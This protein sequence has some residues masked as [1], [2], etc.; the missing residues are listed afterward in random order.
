MK[1]VA[2]YT[3]TTTANEKRS[4]KSRSHHR[5]HAA[6]AKHHHGG[7]QYLHNRRGG[8]EE[9]EE[10]HLSKRAVGDVVSATID[11]QL[12]SWIN[13]Y[14]GPGV[15]TDAPVPGGANDASASTSDMDTTEDT[16]MTSQG[17]TWSSSTTTSTSSSSS[18]SSTSTAPASNGGWARQAYFNA[19]SGTAEGLTFLNHFGGMDGIPG[20]SAGG[21][22]SGN[23]DH[24]ATK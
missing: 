21:P 17:S 16:E 13:V 10:T 12:V 3:P 4:T 11:G 22:A 18:S 5:R 14:A 19:A 2:V 8:V 15:A 20:T 1:Q 9:V 23:L 7:H 6:A 24:A